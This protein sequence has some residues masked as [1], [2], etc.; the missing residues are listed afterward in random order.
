MGVAFT[1]PVRRKPDPRRVLTLPPGSLE[2]IHTEPFGPQRVGGTV[3]LND[4]GGRA[5]YA[6]FRA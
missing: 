6:I 2:A 1:C 4:W 3:K 5:D